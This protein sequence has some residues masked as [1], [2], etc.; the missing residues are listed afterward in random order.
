MLEQVTQRGCGYPIP[1]RIEDQAG[2]GSE[3]HDL[4]EDVPAYCRG[5]ELDDF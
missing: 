3:Q 5:L 4:A 1:G 2:R